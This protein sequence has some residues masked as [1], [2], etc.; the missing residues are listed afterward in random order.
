MLVV[1]LALCVGIANSAAREAHGNWVYPDGDSQYEPF[2]PDGVPFVVASKLWDVDMRG[3]H[4]AVVRV[5]PP[6]L[7]RADSTGLPLPKAE[8][9]AGAEVVSAR[10]IWRRP[11]L[12]PERKRVIV[13]DAADR[14]VKNVRCEV[15]RDT[16]L[17]VFKPEYGAGDY[18]IYYLPYKFRGAHGD[19]RYG[20][21]YNDYLRPEYKNDPAWEKKAAHGK[22]HIVA[23]VL[24]F[25]SRT[26]LDFWT[27]T[28]LVASD[29]EIDALKKFVPAGDFR[30][31]T[32]DRA[33]PI[34]L[35]TISAHWIKRDRDSDSYSFAGIAHP[36]EYYTWQIGLW[37]THKE[38]RHVNIVFSDFT[39]QA[40]GGKTIPANEIT[41]FNLGGV[42]WD[43]K[44]IRFDVNVPAGKVQALWCGLQ[45]PSFA[46]EGIYK[47]TATIYA[48]NSRPQ[49][50][51]ISIIVK[52][53]AFADKGDGEPWRHSR[54]R[55]LNSTIG[56]DNEPVA[57]Y[58]SLRVENNVI[59]GSGKTFSIGKN[60]LP[61]NIEVNGKKIFSKPP[62]FIVETGEKTVRFDTGDLKIE[63]VAGGLVRWRSIGEQSGLRFDCAAS[64]EADGYLRYNIRLSA[65]KKTPVKNI[66]LRTRHTA[67]SSVYFMG[68]GHKGGTR[69]EGY[70]WKWKGPWDSH[71]IGGS[72]SGLH[73]EYRGG[74]YHGP[75]INDYKPAPPKVWTNGGRGTVNVS[76]ATG[77]DAT[78]VAS[79]GTCVV[80][81]TPL[82]FEFS[83]LA[84]PVKPLDTAKQFSMRFFHG[85]SA[86]F[87]RAASEDGVNIANIHHA[88]PLNPVINYPFIVR[89]P[90]KKFIQEQHAQNRKVKLYYTIRE[91]TTWAP[92]VFALN[93]LGHEIFPTGPGYGLP[94]YCEH[95]IEDYKPAWFTELPNKQQDAALVLAGFSRWINYYL[96]GLR[97]MCE[98]YEIDGIYMDDVSFDRS[99][100]KRI[101]KILAKHRPGA[102]IDLHSN[103]A[104]SVGAANQ[105]ADFFPYV[106]R[107]WFGESFR[108]NAMTPAEWFVTF[109]GIPFGVM[110]EM[111]QGGGNRWLG[112]V[113]GT[114]ARHRGGVL[115]PVPVWKL[116]REFGI[117]NAKMLG[118]WDAGRAVETGHPDIK[119][120]AFIRAGKTLIALGNFGAVDA[121]AT[122]TLDWAKLGLKPNAK[123][124]APF[125]ENF[126]EAR[127]IR[128][129]E[130]FVVPAKKGWL[131]WVE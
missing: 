38:A 68:A 84:T 127:D 107:L 18:Y 118:Y 44:P 74:T 34:R 64:L 129:N 79:T 106:D 87:D 81:K 104:Y 102:L 17:V 60:G 40:Y 117:E 58:E 109:S 86:N 11:D 73:T 70:T 82:D 53:N 37:A 97:W 31:F 111:L 20:R 27:P 54:L 33:Y 9:A 89:E 12:H 62:E 51:N 110:S 77:K 63:K 52:G 46:A 14:V 114:T 122:L 80:A 42:N 59:S 103:T 15:T 26:K 105:Y 108:Y 93:S 50:V 98:N 94:W 83:F 22:P 1:A 36:N 95:L 113:Y 116:W 78:V 49:K 92:E 41:C 28:G 6:D 23:E 61:E 126:Q 35:K 125:V 71:W 66:A 100:M 85:N 16:G 10:L 75:L 90:L 96:E 39:H 8:P 131:I 72:A 128:A 25:E 56:Q 13:T 124:R 29:A 4:R 5:T 115:S 99:V 24:C 123:L 3:N 30:L 55:W 65:D 43:G 101:R 47:G 7:V 119:A 67:K 69:P 32:E 48:E 76:G 19:A 130:P 88:T 112:A 21:P 45:I 120:T 57:P 91:L 2:A 121:P